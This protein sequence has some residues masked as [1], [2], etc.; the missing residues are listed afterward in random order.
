MT[1]TVL[2]PNYKSLNKT[3]KCTIILVDI[4]FFKIWWLL[5]EPLCDEV[6]EKI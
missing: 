3:S 4:D 1:L 2:A 6:F 5:K